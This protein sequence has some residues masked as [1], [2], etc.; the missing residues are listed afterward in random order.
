N[1]L[2]SYQQSLYNQIY[3]DFS[4]AT[5]VQDAG[6]LLTGT[7]LLAQAY[8]NFGLPNSLQSSDALHSLL[9]G[10]QSILDAS[11][12]Q[13]D[14]FGFSTASIPDTTNK[15]SVDDISLTNPRLSAL[16]TS[17]TSALNQV[18]HSQIPESLSQVDLTLEDLQAFKALKD[19]GALSSCSFQLSG[20]L[21]VV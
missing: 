7:K 12:V 16:S 1:R 10:S 4:A 6:Q 14:F 20:G 8:V 19:A 17:I 3:A 9:Y 13:S 5:A 15:K 11:A 21:T 2:K 18:Q